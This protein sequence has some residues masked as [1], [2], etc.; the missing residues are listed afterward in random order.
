MWTAG[1]C[2]HSGSG[3]NWYSNWVFIPAYDDDLANP[4]PYG[5]WTPWWVQTR[6]AWASNSD[7]PRTW[8]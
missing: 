3:G 2:L 1:H 5:T 4:R 8:A 6:P 7:I